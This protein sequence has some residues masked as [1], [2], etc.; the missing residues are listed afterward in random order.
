MK[1]V[2]AEKPSVAFTS[3]KK[4]ITKSVATAL[5][6]IGRVNMNNLYSGKIGKT[7]NAIVIL[8]DTGDKYVN[9]KL[10]F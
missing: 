5:L 4:S 6:K 3:K 8:D 1:L 2:I 9:F 7:Y 10:K